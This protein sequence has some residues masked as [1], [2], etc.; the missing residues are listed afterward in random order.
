M[1]ALSGQTK[2]PIGAGTVDAIR[3]FNRFY[4]KKAG[5][6]QRGLL[7]SPYSLT[8]VRVLYELAHRKDLTAS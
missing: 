2:L 5:L 4:T 3:A 6:L 8:E 1:G 7:D